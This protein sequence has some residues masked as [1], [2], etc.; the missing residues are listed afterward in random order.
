MASGVSKRGPMR[1]SQIRT[2]IQGAAREFPKEIKDSKG[3]V[4][5]HSSDFDEWIC[6]WQAA[7]IQRVGRVFWHLI[8]LPGPPR[9]LPWLTESSR[10]SATR[11]RGHA[12]RCHSL[13]SQFFS[14]VN[15]Q[16][17]AVAFPSPPK[18]FF[19]LW[20]HLAKRAPQGFLTNGSISN[21]HPHF[22]APTA[23]FARKGV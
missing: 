7:S 21:F 8:G 18:S 13:L 20:N 9:P 22:A 6:H 16:F 10:S 11:A 12:A 17:F 3:E 1:A 5:C 15:H 4:F 2:K 23:K 19:P 14:V